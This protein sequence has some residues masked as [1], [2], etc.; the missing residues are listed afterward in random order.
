MPRHPDCQSCLRWSIYQDACFHCKPK[1]KHI[2]NCPC[3]QCL[4]KVTCKNIWCDDFKAA[5]LQH[6]NFPNLCTE[7]AD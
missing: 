1:Y 7:V 5:K 3:K 4:V 6:W 2:G